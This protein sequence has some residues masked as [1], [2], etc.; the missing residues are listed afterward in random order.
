MKRVSKRDIRLRFDMIESERLAIERLERGHAVVAVAGVE[1]R[2]DLTKAE[3]GDLSIAGGYFAWL[4]SW[5]NA[6]GDGSPPRGHRPQ[7]D[8][9]WSLYRRQD[10]ARVCFRTRGCDFDV[11]TLRY[12][13]YARHHRVGK[14]VEAQVASVF[15]N[16][17]RMRLAP[18]V[19]AT[20]PITDYVDRLPGWRRVD[21][22][23]FPVPE[24]LQVILRHIDADRH[25]IRV[26]LHGY[27]RDPKYCNAESGYRGAYDAREGLFRYLP[28][29]RD[30]E[31]S[32]SHRR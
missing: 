24:S 25:T 32:R 20:M 7:E 19:W 12:R 22:G 17:V 8:D 23:R 10:R 4:D 5:P 9:T 14:L 29:E 26:T 2:L 27:Q 21:L 15:S 6:I 13:E 18:G 16:K 1:C 3:R 31:T 28:W 11:A 30:D